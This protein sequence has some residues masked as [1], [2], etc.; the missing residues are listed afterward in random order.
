MVK[1]VANLFLLNHIKSTYKIIPVVLAV[2]ANTH[3]KLLTN[4][5]IVVKKTSTPQSAVK[6]PSMPGNLVQALS[7]SATINEITYRCAPH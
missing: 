5:S 7:P 4:S 1:D 6:Q 3:Y 2:E